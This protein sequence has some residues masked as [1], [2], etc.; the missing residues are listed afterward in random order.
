ML[1]LS[2][3]SIDN[4]GILS[5]ISSEAK[6]YTYDCVVKIKEDGVDEIFVKQNI[7]KEIKMVGGCVEDPSWWS[8]RISGC[9]GYK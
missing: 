6:Q 8:R 2:D 4:G 5:K 1:F 7:N 9:S 3:S